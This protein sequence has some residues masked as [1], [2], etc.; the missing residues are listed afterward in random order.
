MFW[1]PV[2]IYGQ[3]TWILNTWK[4][5]TKSLIK[6]TISLKLRVAQKKT[7]ELKNHCHIYPNLPCKFGHFWTTF[8]FVVE[9]LALWRSITQKLKIGRIWNIIFHSIQHI[10]H[11]LC[12]DG[13]FWK[14]GGG[15]AYPSLWY[16][17]RSNTTLHL[18]SQIFQ[19]WS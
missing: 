2:P 10:P 19:I 5:W 4:L 7:H 14:G 15:S 16:G 1:G 3:H 9:W 18:I 17:H 6:S 8:F 12:K 11:I 13:H